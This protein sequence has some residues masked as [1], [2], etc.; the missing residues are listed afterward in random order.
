MILLFLPYK[1]FIAKLEILSRTEIGIGE[2]D[3]RYVGLEKTKLLT[4]THFP[5][6]LYTDSRT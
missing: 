2:H 5:V 4:K 3:N 6:L 1:K